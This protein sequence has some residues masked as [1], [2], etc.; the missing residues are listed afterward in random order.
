M[1]N[2]IRE[3][4]REY[5]TVK[6]HGHTDEKLDKFINHAEFKKLITPEEFKAWTDVEVLEMAKLIRARQQELESELRRRGYYF[7]W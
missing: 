6:L 1:T 3:A 7:R 2:V 5:T 4:L